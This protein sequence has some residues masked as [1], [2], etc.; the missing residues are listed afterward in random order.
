M[1]S[2]RD[3]PKVK[4]SGEVGS[5]LLLIATAPLFLSTETAFAYAGPV[6]AISK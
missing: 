4:Q 5:R 3:S 1:T 6:Q 2:D